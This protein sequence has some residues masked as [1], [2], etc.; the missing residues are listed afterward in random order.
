MAENRKPPA[1]Q[2]Y[3]SNYA[4]QYLVPF[5]GSSTKRPTLYNALRM[6]G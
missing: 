4:S 6:L 3:A 5:Y 1:Y 2:E